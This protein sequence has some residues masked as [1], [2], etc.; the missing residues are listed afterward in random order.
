MIAG[1]VEASCQL[2]SISSL[3]RKA[4]RD[5]IK[6]KN[7]PPNTGSLQELIFPPDYCETLRGDFFLLHDSGAG[8]GNN[9]FLVF[10]ITDNLGLLSRHNDLFADGTFITVPLLFHQLYSLCVRIDGAIIPA[11][12]ALLPNR[13]QAMYEA[14]LQ[15]LKDNN[16]DLNPATIMTDF[17]ESA[18]NA[19]RS[20]FP[21][22]EC[23]GCFFHLCQNI[24][25]RIQQHGLQV[26]Y[27]Q[28]P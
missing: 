10:S 20:K 9:R 27:S 26:R 5:R 15:V 13:T 28:D 7:V 1:P 11:V 6:A 3:K 22:I 8:T 25:R 2:F 24:F 16:A 19:F 4:Q 18:I 21:G 14:M 12:Y 23:K 17:E